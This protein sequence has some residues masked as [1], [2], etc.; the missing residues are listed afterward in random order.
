MDFDKYELSDE[1]K[2]SIKADYEASIAGLKAKNADLIEREQKQRQ[3]NEE[4][5]VQ[6]ASKEEDAKVALAEKEGDIEKYKVAVA[7]RDE[8]LAK[9]KREFQEVEN[10]RLRDAALNDFSTSLT[11]DPAGR[12]YMQSKFAESIDIID[13][14]VKPKDVTKSL[15]ELK[16]ALVSDKANASYVKA[17]VG[18]GTG[19][20]G[21]GGS[22]S[23]STPS[24]KP[25]KEMSKEE[26]IDYYEN[27][28]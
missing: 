4:L 8:V 7:E 22:G 6:M 25:Y 9:T 3:A 12:M 28:M 23:A 27:K 18:S 20:A 17:P 21:S 2:A 10:G 16:Q 11:D 14:Q 26:K 24:N 5:A 19:S 15:D 13:G 1:V